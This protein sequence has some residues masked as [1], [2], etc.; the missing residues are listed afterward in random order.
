[1]ERKQGLSGLKDRRLLIISSGC[2]FAGLLAGM[3]I[4]GSPWLPPAWGDIPTW[5]EAIATIGLL[6]GAIVTAIYAI[7]AFRGQAEMLKVQSEQLA[8]QRRLNIRQTEVL[9][10]Q[11][12]ELRE[13]LAERK[14]EALERRNAQGAQTHLVVKAIHDN[15]AFGG[16]VIEATLVNAAERQQPAYDAK[17]YWHL[18]PD[19]YGTPNPEPLGTILNWEKEI[20]TRPFPHGADP[21]ACGAVLSFRDAFGVG[22]VKT[23]DGGAMHADSELVPDIVKALTRGSRDGSSPGQ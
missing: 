16:P 17:L 11:A 7:R 21:A 10:L 14:R 3:L 6:A 2:A 15:G 19:G 9:E 4:F 12:A 20:R 13:S 22:W 18:G 8:E 1:M 5:I 23:P